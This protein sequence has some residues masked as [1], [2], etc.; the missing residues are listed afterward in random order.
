MQIEILPFLKILIV[1]ILY[2]LIITIIIYPGF[3]RFGDYVQN[4]F[5]E[6]KSFIKY[7]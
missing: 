1:E 2:N 6:D 3:Q 4:T 7:L 5:T